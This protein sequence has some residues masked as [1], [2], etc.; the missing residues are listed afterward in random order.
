MSDEVTK[1]SV[2]K[3]VRGA[4]HV[5]VLI[6]GGGPVGLS[7][8]GELGWRGVACELVEQGDGSIATP[9]MNEVNTRT[10]EFCRRW[11]IAQTVRDCP[12]PGDHSL[13]VV[14]VTSLSG[15]ELARMRRATR[16][17]QTADSY[18]PERLQIC[19]Q[20]WFDPILQA[21]ARSQSGVTLRY[22]TQLETFETTQSGIRAQLH[23]LPTGKREMFTAD[24]LVG[25]DGAN[26]AVRAALGI[27][28]QG[29]GTLGH[30]LHLYFRAP[31]LLARC[32]RQPGVFFLAIDRN[33]LWANIRVIDPANGLWRLMVLDSDGE[34][35]PETIDRNALLARAVGQ[36]IDVEWVG[37]SIWTR[38][39]VVADHYGNGRVFLAGDAVHQLS[40]TGAL[41]M[42][43]GIG[44]AVDLGWKLAAVLQG[45]GGSKLLDSY[46]S[47]R[48]PIG[49]RNVRMA[50]EFYIAH[51][52]F[53][54][55]LAEIEDDSDAGRALR[56]GL[57][58][59]L[60]KNVGRMFRTEGLQLGYR[61][62]FSPI[63]VGDV[64][65]PPDE[66]ERYAPSTHPGSRAPHVWLRDGRSTLDLFGRGFV[67]LKFDEA[68]TVALG[69][70]ARTRGVPLSVIDLDEPEAAAL[71]ERR[72]VLVRPDGHVAWR[73]EKLP[74]DAAA[75]IDRV[76]GAI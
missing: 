26:S 54:D 62:G 13:D 12:F 42:N 55:R 10:M 18:S 63:C 31:H 74:P 25:C 6:V 52:G 41:G 48:R 39:S 37:L 69:E 23:D 5:P 19:S 16:S 20:L 11:G 47:E 21:F 38:K 75:L 64:P 68:E 27:G 73:G 28:L 65:S 44:D 9:K 40:P 7:L 61:Y 17:Q 45:W 59:G 58:E 60:L 53:D 66:P 35:T 14:F 49:L 15:Y 51:G 46:D 3:A 1:S 36:P 71:Y 70:A 4:R 24:Y 29:K 43:T 22:R 50:T 76:R 67:L 32:G 30:P 72:L 57:G 33:G 8:A 2:S 56:Q 34:Q